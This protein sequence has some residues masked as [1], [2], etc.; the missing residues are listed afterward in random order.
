V[1]P[2]AVVIAPRVPE[3][4]RRW[5]P[6]HTT[7]ALTLLLAFVAIVI[8]GY[9]GHWSWTG[10]TGNTVW[11]WLNL[12]FLPLLVPTVVVPALTPRV[13]GEVVYL[14]AHGNPIK[15][16]VV[17]AGVAEVAAQG[18]AAAEAEE[19]AAP[20]GAAAATESTPAQPD[21]SPDADGTAM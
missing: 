14:D 12:L 1:L 13:M 10:F 19:P 18:G 20:G 9:T 3:L 6:R 15:V 16:E 4:R 21:A 2:L 17:D 8:G 5:G 7:A 11:N